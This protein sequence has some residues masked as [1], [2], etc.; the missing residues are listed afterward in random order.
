MYGWVG[1]GRPAVGRRNRAQRK[2]AT[3][4]KSLSIVREATDADTRTHARTCM[5][6]L[7]I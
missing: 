3:S 1:M 5:I 6:L 7:S 2:G 4:W